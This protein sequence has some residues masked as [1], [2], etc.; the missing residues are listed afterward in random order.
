MNIK[1]IILGIVTTMAVV[2]FVGCKDTNDGRLTTT[3]VKFEQKD[4]LAEVTI[5]VD[6][7]TE[8]GQGLKT[9]ISEYINEQLGGTDAGT[10]DN[11][12]SIVQY[13]GK[14]KYTELSKEN[15][16]T[17]S[18]M[19]FSKM[20]EIKKAAETDNYVTYTTDYEDFMGGAHGSRIFTG[21]T[22]RKADGRRFGY[23]M[24][25]NTESEEFH[26]L[27]KEGLK[28]YFE[29]PKM[30]DEKLKDMLMVEDGVDYLPL[31]ISIPYLTDKGM[32]FTYQQYEIAAYAAGIPTFTI[33]FSKIK[34]YLTVTVL[35]MI[36]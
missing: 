5:S 14:G 17:G 1:T 29:D 3:Q 2:S 33:P 25:R 32:V 7:P 15:K 26:A 8:A 10:L 18:E 31:P 23:E 21:V 9:A 4:K 11:G 36:K 6:Y 24:L 19:P 28:E 22:F 16:E 20:Y 30:S 12:D 35:K 34:P 27:I 13:Y